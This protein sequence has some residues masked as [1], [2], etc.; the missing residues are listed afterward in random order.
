VEPDSPA[1]IARNIL[2]DGNR[3]SNIGGSNIIQFS[4]TN[5]VV[6][7]GVPLQD[8]TI[9]NNV[10]TGDG[11]S[12]GIYL[13]QQF[14]HTTD[15]PATNV[16]IRGN[17]VSNTLRA[18]MLLGIKQVLIQDNLFDGCETAPYIS[19]SEK[20]INVMNMKITGNTFRNLSQT[21]GM[22][23]YIF[24]VDTLEINNNTFDNI[25]KRDG[26]GGN[27]LNFKSN[28]RPALAVTI[29]NNVFKGARTQIAI[30]R[31]RYQITDP[32]K[33]SIRQNDFGGMKALLPAQ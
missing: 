31:D 17:K 12:S 33:N 5:H 29:R 8:I 28:G 32:E 1:N 9:S 24:G 20:N 7:L 6:K 27:A 13:G 2:V 4:I 3:F 21:D 14:L 23:I 26:S 19:Y 15:T 25:G 18:F 11:S 22:G 16:V 10:I 30:Q